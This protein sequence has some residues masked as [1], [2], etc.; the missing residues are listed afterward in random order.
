MN[1]FVRNPRF[2]FAAAVV[3][4]L[5]LV[6]GGVILAQLLNLAACPL[7]ILQRMLYLL[8]ALVGAGGLAAA[9]PLARRFAALAMAAVAGTG[10]V[11]AGYQIWIQRFAHDTNCVANAPWWEQLVDWAGEKLPLLFGVSGLC[12]EP[13]WKLLGLSIAEWSLLAFSVL[14]GLAAFAAL[15]KMRD[16]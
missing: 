9:R 5:S 8:L 13:P 11:V 3:V 16:R 1:K 10:A 7:C 4:S 2:P 6:I 15:R 12:S 14:F